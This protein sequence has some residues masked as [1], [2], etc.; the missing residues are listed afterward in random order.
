MLEKS[1]LLSLSNMWSTFATMT[2]MIVL[3]FNYSK[4]TIINICIGTIQWLLEILPQHNSGC[5][6]QI[7][8]PKYL[9]PFGIMEYTCGFDGKRI[10]ITHGK[11]TEIKKGFIDK[12]SFNDTIERKMI[13][14]QDSH[15]ITYGY[16]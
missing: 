4:T 2:K 9:R 10:K 5:V 12:N 15:Y 7:T 1:A 8:T 16:Y 3:L 14:Q 6:Y 13:G 11:A